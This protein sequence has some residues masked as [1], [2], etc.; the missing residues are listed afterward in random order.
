LRE[1]MAADSMALN[2][3]RF[4]TLGNDLDGSKANT[5]SR[6]SPGTSSLQL[7]KVSTVGPSV[8]DGPDILP[9]G[10]PD[11]Q[12]K[13]ASLR[14]IDPS[15]AAEAEEELLLSTIE[16]RAKELI[17]MRGGRQELI[18]VASLL[19]RIPNLAGLARTCEVSDTQVEVIVEVQA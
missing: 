14:F 17:R 5:E 8:K 19:A 12:K 18:V 7:D 3:E 2:A 11:I 1:S 10:N 9:N 15:T 6:S 16:S 4:S 13:M